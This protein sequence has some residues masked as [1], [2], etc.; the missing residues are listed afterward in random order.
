L[1]RLISVLCPVYNEEEN[2]NMFY[3]SV[4]NILIDSDTLKFE[5]L[6]IDDG[7]TDR[8]WDIIKE[9]CKENLRFKA[10]KLSRNHGAHK[11]LA[12]GYHI[13]K[14]DAAVMLACDLQDPPEIILEFIEKW[15]EGYHIVWGKRE[16]RNDAHWKIFFSQ[17]FEKLIKKYAAPAGS[18]F[19]TGSF[20]LADK[21]VIEMYRKFNEH[22]RVTFAIF[23][24]IGFKQHQISYH[25]KERR[26]GSS[27]WTFARMINALYDAFIAFS[28]APAILLRNF[29]MIAI[30]CFIPFA[31]YVLYLYFS[32]RSANI[33]WVSVVLVVYFFSSLILFNLSLILDY[34]IRVYL[35]SADRPLYF[36]EEDLYL[37]EEAKN[38]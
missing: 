29:S 33:G 5:V 21:K 19:T 20:F 10:I 26:R 13:C 36:I 15:K 24:H 35:N 3:R 14:G 30:V 7:S 2:L 6:F 11:A 25:R 31:L 9:I 12:A 38:D 4:E 17:L 8:S 18:L 22:N 16:T 32:G 28:Y 27:G 34:L 1:D 23:A 37:M